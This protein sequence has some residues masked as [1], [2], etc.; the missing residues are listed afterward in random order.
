[1]LKNVQPNERLVMLDERGR[2]VSSDELANLIAGAGDR[3]DA[4]LVF[5][6]GGPFG[7]GDA[8]RYLRPCR[9]RSRPGA[10][11]ADPK[12]GR[13]RAKAAARLDLEVSQGRR[14][15]PLAVYGAATRC[16]PPHHPWPRFSAR[17]A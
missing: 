17:T 15:R 1:V 8:V 4:A 10:G 7:H 13:S 2:E 6:I 14:A 11:F 5:A 12:A 9:L 3:G 16:C